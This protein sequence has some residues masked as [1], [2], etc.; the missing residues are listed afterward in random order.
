MCALSKTEVV[1]GAVTI[2][3]A[4]V[5][6][7]VIGPRI[8][9]ACIVVGFI[10]ILCVHLCWKDDSDRPEV[11]LEFDKS[12]LPFDARNRWVGQRPIYLKNVGKS[13]AYNVG[14]EEVIFDFGTA[15]QKTPIPIME[16]NQRISLSPY[17]DTRADISG[18]TEFEVFL[19][20]Q[21]TVKG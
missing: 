21:W 16:P 17:I 18:V 4:G 14:L 12:R 11:I 13:H 3:S 5:T 2:M 9:A 6:Y 7:F 8:A 15:I 20:V 10:V 19:Q 1:S